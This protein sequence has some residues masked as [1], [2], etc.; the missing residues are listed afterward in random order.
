MFRSPH[1]LLRPYASAVSVFQRVLDV[2]LIAIS[3]V[4]SSY[5][6]IA[7]L[8]EYQWV[9]LVWLLLFFLFFSQAKGLYQSWRLSSLSSEITAIMLV[10]FSS[11]ASLIVL[12][13]L[14]KASDQYS[15]VVIAVWSMAAPSLMIILRIVVRSWLKMA[16]RKGWNS[17][18]LA[19][20]GA[21]DLAEKLALKLGCDGSMGIK[22]LGVFDDQPPIETASR[23]LVYQGSTSDL[24]HVAYEGN[25]DYVYITLPYRDED[26]IMA[27]I[28]ALA[29]TTATVYVVPDIFIRDLSHA[30]W[31]SMDGIPMVS[32]FESPFYGTDG[33]LKRV[34]DAVLGGLILLIIWPLLLMI[35]LAVKLTSPGPVLFKQRR[36]GL[37]GEVIEVWKFRS[38]TSLDNDADVPQATREDPRITKLG[39]FLR[40]S[41]LDELPQFIN[42]IQ[43]KMSI[44]GPRPHAVAHNEQYR[45]LIDGYML[46]HYVK[47]GI[48]G[49][50]QIHGWRGETDTLD[51]MKNRVEFDLD[52]I[53]NWS[54]G[55]DLKI[56]FMTIFKGFVDKNAY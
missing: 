56:I 30:R 13:F 33:W 16:R 11:L 7:N 23:L 55:L 1:G 20:A 40:K 27:L 6:H 35:A 41:S 24:L 17:R 8:E 28:K 38:M 9:A 34:E 53:H 46:R 5:F 21:G 4:G 2:C 42:V 47:P 14:L 19:F 10:W 51:K 52:Y 18:T 36:Y 48:T 29:D 49:W 26:K 45:K 39:R 31:F 43:G 15:R 12:A 44:V 32:V 25:L 50:A 37:R 54:L 3:F 22:V